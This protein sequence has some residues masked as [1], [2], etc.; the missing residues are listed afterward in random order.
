M[1]ALQVVA[2][3]GDRPELRCLEK[4][5]PYG[6]VL[7][8]ALHGKPWPPL[9]DTVV[10]VCTSSSPLRGG[11]SYNNILQ[12]LVV[13]VASIVLFGAAHRAHPLASA[14][15]QRA[16]SAEHHEVGDERSVLHTCSPAE[17]IPASAAPAVPSHCAS[18]R[19]AKLRRTQSSDA[20][21]RPRTVSVPAEL[22]KRRSCMPLNS[23][24]GKRAE[25]PVHIGWTSSATAQK[26]AARR[27]L[28]L[29]HT[30]IS[31][32]LRSHADPRLAPSGA[33]REGSPVRDRHACRP[34]R[35]PRL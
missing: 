7:D 14:G 32:L 21:A 26:R 33:A 2:L 31:R 30:I 27:A 24:N 18:T 8:S 19:A 3:G 12:I 13:V 23:S 35:R 6:F 25:T 11:S 10:R 1:A 20:P 15:T 9:I 5:T 29:R 17:D 28:S 4:L 22:P 16:S 34:G